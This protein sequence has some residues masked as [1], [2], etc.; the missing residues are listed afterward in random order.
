MN[1]TPI[2]D[3]AAYMDQ[4]GRRARAAARVLAAASTAQK[5]AAL[6]AIAADLDASRATLAAANAKDL[7]AGRAKGLEAALLDRLT[8]SPKV[9][10]A[11]I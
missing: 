1:D 9:V 2:T 4:L 10:D 5:N 8:V 11:M 7:E 6:A 3:V